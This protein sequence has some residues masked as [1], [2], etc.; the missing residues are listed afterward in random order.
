MFILTDVLGPYG[1]IF[2]IAVGFGMA[3][4]SHCQE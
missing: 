1:A 3:I 4:K 2:G